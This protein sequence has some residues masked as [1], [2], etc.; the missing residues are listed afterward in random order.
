M[1][2]IRKHKN[3]NYTIMSNYHLKDKNLSLEA[4]GLLSMLLLFSDNSELTETEMYKYL[5]EQPDFV[6]N[7]LSELEETG[8]I[9]R[10]QL[11]Q[12]GK[13]SGIEYHILDK[14]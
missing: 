3:K 11:F 14:N 8:Y 10:K 6:N 9:L 2:V 1:S 5:K 12:N 4:V 13:F 7:V